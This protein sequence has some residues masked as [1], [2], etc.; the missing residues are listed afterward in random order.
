MVVFLDD[1]PINSANLFGM[2]NLR[3]PGI[4]LFFTFPVFL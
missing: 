1:G 2:H 4:F 3:V